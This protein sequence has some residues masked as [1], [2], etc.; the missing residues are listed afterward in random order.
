MMNKVPINI[1]LSNAPHKHS[2]SQ[3]DQYKLFVGG[4][5]TTITADV[6]S[7]YFSQFG[8]ILSSEPQTWSK[9]SQKCRGFGVVCCRDQA[10]F[11]RI[12]NHPK[13][14]LLGRIIECSPYFNDKTRL[15]KHFK[16]VM[17]RKIFVRGLSSRIS[18]E[19]LENFFS[20]YGE[21][22]IAYVVN[23]KKTGK[24]KGFGYICYKDTK[25][26]ERV[27]SL[28]EFCVNGKIVNCYRYNK[29]KEEA[30]LKN[31]AMPKNKKIGNFNKLNSEKIVMNSLTKGIIYKKIDNK[32]KKEVPLRRDSDSPN[33]ISNSTNYESE[34]DQ[35]LNSP[36]PQKLDE[37][38]E[39]KRV[40][41]KKKV[42]DYTYFGKF[43]NR[44][45][46]RKFCNSSN[47]ERLLN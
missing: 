29:T 3:R 10:T 31:N 30:E 33:Q 40:V 19:D 44:N 37:I 5:P 1:P 7:V 35:E 26:T 15:T 6:L 8:D 23:H 12:L 28:G 4:L 32:L 42:R 9:K 39:F 43:K 34:V 11:D 47:L 16:E 13:H 27:L 14:E 22:E 24:S 17:K 18:T 20:R 46:F 21:L 41:K 25:I 36:K 45:L 2:N 38:V